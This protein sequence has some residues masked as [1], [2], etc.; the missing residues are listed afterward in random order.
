MTQ[1]IR[2]FGLVL[3]PWRFGVVAASGFV[4]SLTAGRAWLPIA[5]A[6]SPALDLLFSAQMVSFVL[7]IGAELF[8]YLGVLSV[9]P[10]WKH[11]TAVFNFAVLGS[12]TGNQLLP[13]FFGWSW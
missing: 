4:F 2:V 13:L 8:L 9:W 1:K 3:A 12:Y 5:N 11:P 10:A 7:M 6:G